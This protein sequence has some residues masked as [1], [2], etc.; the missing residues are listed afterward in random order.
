[1]T[2]KSLAA[3]LGAVLA[4][5][6]GAASAIDLKTYP[7]NISVQINPNIVK[8]LPGAL[9]KA[10]SGKGCTFYEN[11][12]GGGESW[13]KP[14]GW[15]AQKYDNQDSYSEYVTTVGEWWDNRISSIQCDESEKVH[16]SVAVYRDVNKGGGDAIFWGSQGLFNLSDWGWDNQ[17][18]SFQI[19][20]NL[21]K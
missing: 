20:C 21:M 1:M 2:L 8:H 3:A 4:L 13:H 15:L 16:C 12:N 9:P 5:Q 17:I 18:S 11:P 19:F 10:I 7:G 6:A 14:V